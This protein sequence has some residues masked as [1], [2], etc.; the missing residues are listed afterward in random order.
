MGPLIGFIGLV[1]MGIAIAG[2]PGV[3]VRHRARFAYLEAVLPDGTTQ[4]Q[5]RLRY[6]GSAHQRGFAIYRASHDGY[7][8]ALC[9]A[10]T[11]SAPKKPSTAP[12]ASAIPPPGPKPPTN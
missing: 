7:K 9:Q 1:G 8:T 6:G 12:A 10:A 5:S 11:P 4:P 2:L 3:Q